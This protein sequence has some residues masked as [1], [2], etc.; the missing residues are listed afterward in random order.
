MSKTTEV[1][2]AVPRLES[3]PEIPTFPRIEVRAAKIADDSA[4]IIHEAV[5]AFCALGSW[6]FVGQFACWLKRP[7]STPGS[8]VKPIPA[9]RASTPTQAM[10]ESLLP[11]K[12]TAKAMAMMVEDLSIGL[13]KVTGARER[14]AKKQSHDA[15]VASPERKRK[16]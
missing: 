5:E 16:R 2:I 12:K 8:R 6:A 10:G 13:T 4:K 3:T 11:K 14:A 7:L 1:L 15:P 9:V